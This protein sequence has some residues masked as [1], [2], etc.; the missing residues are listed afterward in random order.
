M[1]K[2]TERRAETFVEEYAHLGT[3]KQKMLGLF[4]RGKSR[5]ARYGREAF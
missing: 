1:P 4:E 5:F 3:R 2:E